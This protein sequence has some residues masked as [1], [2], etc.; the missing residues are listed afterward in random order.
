MYSNNTVLL[1]DVTIPLFIGKNP[2]PFL[3]S[4][5]IRMFPLFKK[6]MRRGSS[7]KFT[8][9][10][11]YQNNCAFTVPAKRN[12]CNLLF[13]LNTM[14]KGSHSRSLKANSNTANS[15]WN[16]TSASIHGIPGQLVRKERFSRNALHMSE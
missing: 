3:C 9:L 6:T 10:R 5:I 1:W 13:S 8:V 11:N 7:L 4:F 2:P 15:L 14:R 16:F 12:I